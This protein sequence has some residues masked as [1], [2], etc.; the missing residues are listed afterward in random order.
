MYEHVFSQTRL[1]TIL[2]IIVNLQEKRMMFN[3]LLASLYVQFVRKNYLLEF[4]KQRKIQDVAH[5]G[6]TE[7]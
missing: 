2:F 7:A 6:R 3:S 1:F 4:A 5:Y